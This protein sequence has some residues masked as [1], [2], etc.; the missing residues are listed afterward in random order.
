MGDKDNGTGGLKRVFTPLGMWSFSI[1]TSIGWGSFI[2]TCNT[3]LLK[4]GLLG[5]IFGLLVGMAVVLVVTWN[6]QYMICSLPDPGGVTVLMLGLFGVILKRK[7]ICQTVPER[8]LL[9]LKRKH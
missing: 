4:S 1:G 5:T 7:G 9:P 8:S 6:L 3:Y 2:I